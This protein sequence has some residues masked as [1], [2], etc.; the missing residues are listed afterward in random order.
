[1]VD[2]KVGSMREQTEKEILLAHPSGP[3]DQAVSVTEEGSA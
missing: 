3:T 1:M 2:M